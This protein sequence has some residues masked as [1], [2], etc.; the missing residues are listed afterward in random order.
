MAPRTFR[1]LSALDRALRL[2]QTPSRV[3]V[4]QRAVEQHGGVLVRRPDK[5]AEQAL[6]QIG[7]GLLVVL[8][9][10]LLG[11]VAQHGAELLL[12]RREVHGGQR[13]VVS[14]DDDGGV[15][16]SASGN[17]VCGSVLC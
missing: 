3:G 17:G 12:L 5:E 6:D 7:G 15:C 1:V 13:L 4:R 2:P 10:E 14:Q 11:Q 8:V 9:A 16:F